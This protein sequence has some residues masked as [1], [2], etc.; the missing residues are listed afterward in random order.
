MAGLPWICSR[1]TF[2]NVQA[3]APVCELCLGHRWGEGGLAEVVE[4]A[5]RD[6]MSN[7][8]H[9]RD[10]QEGS[11][12]SAT[13]DAVAAVAGRLVNSATGAQEET[14]PRNPGPPSWGRDM[15]IYVLRLAGGKWYVG[16]THDPENRWRAHVNQSGSAWTRQF[17]PIEL[18]LVKPMLSRHDEDTTTLDLMDKHGVDNVR[19]GAYVQLVLPA[20][21]MREIQR[22]TALLDDACF[23][24]GE[25]GHMITACPRADQQGT[26]AG[27]GEAVPA[28]ACSRCGRNTHDARDCYARKHVDGGMPRLG[29]ASNSATLKRQPQEPS[30]ALV[31][32]ERCGRDT[33]DESE[34]Y[35]TTLA[36]GF[37]GRPFIDDSSPFDNDGGGPKTKRGAWLSEDEDDDEDA[38]FR[39]G[40][41]GHWAATCYARTNV[42]GYPL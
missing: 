17:A 36:P 23:G 25:K 29:R 37:T 22:R 21:Q 31:G 11:W 3:A 41:Q 32:C 4:V 12:W 16:K 27:R 9:D 8:N 42:D 34:C 5:K 10:R 7:S 30:P 2:R 38:C 28:A 14:P 1:C 20:E 35:A 33:H 18:H 13:W 6:E 26:V 40:R 15:C 24:C 19:G 39:C